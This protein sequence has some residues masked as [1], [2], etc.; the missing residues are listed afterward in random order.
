MSDRFRQTC[1]WG[2]ELVDGGA[3]FRL[4]APAHDEISLIVSD[5]GK[6]LPMARDDAGWFELVTDKLPVGFGYQFRLP[7]GLK[8]PDP[9]ARAQKGDVHGPSLL[10]DPLAYQ[11][12]KPDWKGRPWEEAVIYE[13]HTGT[14]SAGGN[15]AGIARQL[16]RLASLGVTA[17]ELLPVA[18]FSGSRGWGYDGVL[19]YAP[20]IAY[21]GPDGLKALVDAAHERGLMV[22]LDVVYNHFGPDGN[23]LAAYAPQFFDAKRHTPWGPAIDFSRP[24]VRSFFIDNALYWLNE[25]RF[26]GLRFDAIDHI[27]DESE[28]PILAELART[29]RETIPDRHIHLTSEDDKNSTALLE[30]G[31]GNQPRSFTAEWNDDWHHA[32]HH[33]LTGEDDGFYQDYVEAPGERLTR[34]LAQG[35]DYQGE[36]SAHR[37]GKPRGE[38]SSHLPPTAFIDFLQNHDQTGNRPFGERIGALAS[39]PAV[40]AAL[41]LLLLSPHIPLL[42]MGEEYGEE[43]P[44]QFFTDFREALAASVREGRRREFSQVRAFADPALRDRIPDP[45]ALETYRDSRLKPE[46]LPDWVREARQAFVTQL[47][48]IR[49]KKIVPLLSRIGADAGE[50]VAQRDRAFAVRWRVSD[51]GAL[52]L[53]ANLADD[54]STLGDVNAGALVFERPPAAGA[55]LAEG[56]LPGWAVVC[57]IEQPGS[58]DLD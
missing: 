23:Y 34:I 24:A 44:F 2:A 50:V 16:D 42:F 32:M 11:W 45:N 48:H 55:A 21:G 20:H 46:V 56:F 47:L 9:A 29:V 1:H 33:V 31:P 17:I 30:F 54:A 35:F 58:G 37:G 28:E 43:T 19:L 13:L 3:H 25:Y 5:T 39:D 49:R 26:D 6:A 22:L 15:F 36:T 52:L 41:A 7:D 12:R 18:Q 27:E 53:A 8:V 14:F 4:W 38:P 51:G 57:G 40:E 10:V